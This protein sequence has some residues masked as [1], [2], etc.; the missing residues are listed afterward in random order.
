MRGILNP[1]NIFNEKAPVART[2]L[3]VA[4]VLIAGTLMLMPEPANAG[5]FEDVATAV[6]EFFFRIVMA[7]L[8]A[9]VVILA[10][11]VNLLLIFVAW[12]ARMFMEFFLEL[13]LTHTYTSGTIFDVGWPVMRDLAN[14]SLVIVF[15]AIGVGTMLNLQTIN[16]R[17]LGRFFVVALLINFTPIITGIIIDLSNIAGYVFWESA[18]RSS[19]ALINSNPFGGFDY[20]GDVFGDIIAVLGSIFSADISEAIAILVKAVVSILINLFLIFVYLLLSLLLFGRTLMLTILVILSPI[21]FI[22]LIFKR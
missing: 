6:F 15:V 1:K 21:A 8:I 18:K 17:M 9:V 4:V 7:F 22:G 13:T 5:F 11:I 14:M 12:I 20:L 2:V 16:K 3:I 19:S 10:A